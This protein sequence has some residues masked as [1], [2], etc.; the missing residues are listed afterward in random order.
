MNCKNCGAP[1]HGY[2]CDYCGSTYDERKILPTFRV[3]TY[4]VPVRT[5]TARAIVDRQLLDNTVNQE[6]ALYIIKNQL[7]NQLFDALRQSIT[8]ESWFDPCTMEQTL[9]ARVS[10]AIPDVDP[11]EGFYNACFNS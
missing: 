2:K 1:L 4:C 7:E 6:H 3:E 5:F 9:G 10:F 8:Y 11:K